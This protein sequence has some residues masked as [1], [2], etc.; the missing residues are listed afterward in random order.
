[1]LLCSIFLVI[2][3]IRHLDV[4][5]HDRPG[6]GCVARR[7]L[8]T[9]ENRSSIPGVGNYNVLVTRSV[10]PTLVN[11]VS[12]ASLVYASTWSGLWAG[13][14]KLCRVYNTTRLSQGNN[15][16][17]KYTHTQY[18][19]SLKLRSCIIWVTVAILLTRRLCLECPLFWV[20]K[21]LR[22]CLKKRPRIWTLSKN[23]G[24]ILITTTTTNYYREH[25]N[26]HDWSKTQDKVKK[27]NNQYRSGKSH[28]PLISYHT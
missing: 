9:L 16:G 3:S 28:L 12:Y 2:P 14:Q 10:W 25:G 11:S 13:Y 4:V 7:S 22:V 8:A 5:L 1:V 24:A 18:I 6:S 17:T 21:C 26:N 15:K 20:R 23:Y 27:I 19:I